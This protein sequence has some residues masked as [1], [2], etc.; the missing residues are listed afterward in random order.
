MYNDQLIEKTIPIDDIYLDTNNP[1]FWSKGVGRPVADLKS[2][3]LRNQERALINMGSHGITELL[4]SI[5]RNGYLPL[6][7]VVVREIDA[8]PGSFIMVEGNRRLA[9]L[10]TL[11]S[12]IEDGLIDEEDINEDYLEDIF[13]STQEL[14]VL[15]YT[16]EDTDNVAWILQGIRHVSGIKEWEPAQSG[17]L[18]ATL[19]DENENIGF[20]AAGEQ[21][22]L[23]PQKVGKRYRTFKALKQMMDDETYGAE[24]KNNYF[25]LFEEAISRKAIKERLGWNDKDY[26]FENT[27]ALH[28]F[29]NWIIED[30]AQGRRIHDPRQM[31]Y[32]NYL[33]AEKQEGL[34][35]KIDDFDLP[36]EKAYEEAK[37]LGDS[38]KDWE[39]ALNKVSRIINTLPFAVIQSNQ[40]GILGPLQEIAAT[41]DEMIKSAQSAGEEE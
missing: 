7:R 21:F 22:G 23:T 32:F 30:N 11:R 4:N 6:D 31:K 9:A 27:D 33:I 8:K 40:S 34:L 15:V 16:G 18:L 38:T 25:N 35:Q 14:A 2:I 29:Y 10:K 3:E 36:I 28:Q 1:R 17:R 26:C 24:A 37:E 20:K 19:I 39:L 41:V 5:L 12:K 13:E